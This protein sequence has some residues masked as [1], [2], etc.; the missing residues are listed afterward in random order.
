MSLT[1]GTTQTS[2]SSSRNQQLAPPKLVPP[3][4]IR[5]P[6]LTKM[7]AVHIQTQHDP[8]QPIVIVTFHTL[9]KECR[10]EAPV[11]YQMTQKYPRLYF[12]FVTVQE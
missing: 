12:A 5:C 2:F 7:A 10:A 4:L 8:S 11:Y 1:W 9:S 3:R 6:D